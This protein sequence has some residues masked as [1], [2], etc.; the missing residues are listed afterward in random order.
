MDYIS[1]KKDVLFNLTSKLLQSLIITM[2][3][4]V[5]V[6]QKT[7]FGF[8]KVL[9][10]LSSSLPILARVV[11]QYLSNQFVIVDSSSL[12]SWLGRI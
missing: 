12:Y 3:I 9:S 10:F 7:G 6:S 2:W 11:E 4:L 8:M 1:N 5:V